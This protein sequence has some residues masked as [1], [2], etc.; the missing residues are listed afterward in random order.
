MNIYQ[1]YGSIIST[2][3]ARTETEDPF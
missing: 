1:A 3:T 2:K